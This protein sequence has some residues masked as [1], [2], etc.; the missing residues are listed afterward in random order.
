MSN[1]RAAIDLLTAKGIAFEVIPH[2]TTFTAEDEAATLHVPE[3]EVLKVLVLDTGFKHAV[4]VIPA[5]S[6]LDMALVREA[7]S[8]ARAQLASESE[9]AADFPSFELGAI[10]PLPSL[11]KVAVYVDPE[12]MLDPEVIFAVDHEES[13]R[14]KTEDLYSGEYVTVTPL[15]RRILTAV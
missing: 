7:L 14:V 15:V 2:K 6:K 11:S 10:P 1:S 12:V 8:D 13:V 4:A 9:T 3:R 5:S